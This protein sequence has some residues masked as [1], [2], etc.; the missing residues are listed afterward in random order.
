MP[1]VDVSRL[2]AVTVDSYGT[3]LR[4]EDPVEALRT[5]MAGRGV[6]RGADTVRAAFHAE[7]S[8][9]RPR[10]ALGRDPE[11]LAALRRECVEVF[12][13]AA[14]AE[15]DADAFVDAFVGAV[16]FRPIDGAEAALDRLRAAGLTL[17]CVA[18]WDISLHEHLR[19]L[20][21]HERFAVVVTSAEAG[22][23]KPDPTIFHHALGLVGVPPERALHIG[24]EDVDREGA[25]AAGLAFEPEPLATL[26][27]RLGL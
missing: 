6:E 18:N 1:S 25:A 17:V 23:E 20:G 14:G 12:L 27:E 3:L 24:N 15:L 21:L 2:D 10:S 9:Y 8:Y 4:L 19:G 16:V 7:A 22:A 26:P 13:D 5:A 11:S